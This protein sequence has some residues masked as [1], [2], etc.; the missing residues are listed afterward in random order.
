ML[1]NA[2]KLMVRCLRARVP[3]IASPPKTTLTSREDASQA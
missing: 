1:V 2:L 3:Q